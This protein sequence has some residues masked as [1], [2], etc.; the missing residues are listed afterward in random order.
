MTMTPMTMTLMMTTTMTMTT[1]MNRSTKRNANN[2]ALQQANKQTNSQTNKQA[3][4]HTNKQT[5]NANNQTNKQTTKRKPSNLQNSHIL[6]SALTSAALQERRRVAQAEAAL[7]KRRCKSV[8]GR[9]WMN[10]GVTSYVQV[11]GG[12]QFITNERICGQR[13]LKAVITCEPA[14][15]PCELAEVEEACEQSAGA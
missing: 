5:N 7:R 13:A 3:H 2:L 1:M 8:C 15:R 12:G 14:L 11:V 9:G 10:H 4:R 6:A